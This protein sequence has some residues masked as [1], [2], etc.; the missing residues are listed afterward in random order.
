MD[1]PPDQQSDASTDPDISPDWWA[2]PIA[3]EDE[4][5]NLQ[6]AELLWSRLHNAAQEA[7]KGSLKRQLLEALAIA[8]SAMLVS[9]NWS[10]PFEPAM[11]MGDR[12]SALPS[13]LSAGQLV[14]LSK[15]APLIA[16]T[17]LRA[18]IADVCWTYGDRQRTDLLLLA[19]DA[20]RAV[21]LNSETWFSVG[22]ESWTRALELIRRRG[23]A[24]RARGD[25]MS[26]ALHERL[27]AATTDDGFMTVQLSELVRSASRSTAETS[28]AFAQHLTQLA[29][30]ASATHLRLAR[31]LEREAVV[32]LNR[33]GD[34]TA[35]HDALARV[36]EL[37]ATEAERRMQSDEAG[38][39]VAGHDL[40]RAI[41]TLR[42]VPRR[43]REARGLDQRLT[44]LRSRLD[45]IRQVSLEQMTRVESEPIDL[46]GSA[47][48][49]RQRVAG[50]EKLEALARFSALLP[51]TDVAGAKEDA[52]EQLSDSISRL[53]GRATFSHDGRKVAAREGSTDIDDKAVFSTLVRNFGIRAEV[54]TVGALVPA[55]ETLTTEHR[56][57]F[58]DLVEICAQSPVISMRHVGLWARGLLHGL[59]GDYPSAV[60]VLVPQ[61]EQLIRLQLKAAGAQTLFVDPDTAVETEKG[62]GALLEMPEANR[63]LGVSLTFELRALLVEKEG[64]NLRNHLAHGLITDSEAWSAYAVY[65]WWLALRM[66][67]VP[68]WNTRQSLDGQLSGSP[69]A[70]G[71]SSTDE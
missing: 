28:T 15:V 25:E 44:E 50:K 45:E 56:F 59:N 7:P 55:Q 30:E 5:A 22:K 16:E 41:A 24:E 36:A 23:N 9:D 48:Q 3:S 64:A 46:S 18:R 71:A 6:Q 67:V 49:A 29:G 63:T 66:V 37:Y 8:T 42:E 40:E 39:L 26:R 2:T 10:D 51:L 52:R 11:R 54:S 65:A 35:A 58:D 60:A 69:T 21:P 32:W 61:L 57:T 17:T 34:S 68:F 27:L 1:V 20:Y 4:D 62:L 43:H 14:L 19:V 13:D 53:F 47:K 31:H 70:D 38:A 33:S 12:R